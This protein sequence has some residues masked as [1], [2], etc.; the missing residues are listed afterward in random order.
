MTIST[1]GIS[2]PL[3]ATS[4]QIRILHSPALNLFKAPSR[5]AYQRHG[6]CTKFNRITPLNDEAL[7]QCLE[8]LICNY[9]HIFQLY[10]FSLVCYFY[11]FA[12]A[13]QS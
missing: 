5:F 9:V 1:D 8:S 11:S 13:F 7:K 10:V 3:L 2:S 6:P 12:S 4:V